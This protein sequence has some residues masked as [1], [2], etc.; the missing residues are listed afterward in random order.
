MCTHKELIIQSCSRKCTRILREGRNEKTSAETK[1]HVHA[2]APEHFSG[3]DES[4]AEKIV[5]AY[6]RKRLIT[7]GKSRRGTTTRNCREFLQTRSYHQLR[8]GDHGAAKGPAFISLTRNPIHKN[9]T[10][11]QALGKTVDS[12]VLMVAQV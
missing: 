9:K 8:C 2:R 12:S 1:F 6:N 4:K 5:Q 3:N 11:F 10:K 7:E